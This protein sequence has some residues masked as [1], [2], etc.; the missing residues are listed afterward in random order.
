MD[1]QHLYDLLSDPKTP[2]L[3][4]LTLVL[5]FCYY[6]WNLGRLPS[7]PGPTP[8]PIL[9]NLLS[10]SPS[11]HTYFTTLSHTYGPIYKL[12][13]GTKTAIII[14]SPALAKE[15]LKDHDSVFSNRDVPAVAKEAAY[16]GKDIV[17]SQYGDEWRMLRK[18][19]VRELLGSSSIEAVYRL[20]R[21]ELRGMVKNLYGRIGEEINVGEV[22]FMTVMNVVTS[23]LWGG[24][25]DSSS[26]IGV[27][28]RKVVSEITDLLGKPNVSDFFPILGRFDLQGSQKKIR[29]L[30]ARF[31]H[32]FDVIIEGRL[33]LEEG[34][35]K[36]CKDFLQLM[37]RMQE[38]GGGKIPF[39]VL[40]LKALLMDMVV[41]GTDTTSNSVEWAVAEL[42]N[43]P[44]T[45]KKAQE[46]LDRVV[47]RDNILEESHLPQLNY[48][49]LVMKEVLRL[50]PALPL[51]VPHCP[52]SS[53]PIGGYIVE[54]GTRVFINVWA[55][56]RDPT[57]WN[58]P[59]EFDPERFL[60]GK[61]DYSGSNFSYFP[62]GSGRR[63]CAGIA[64][65]DRMFMY[66]LA[67]LLH[68]FDWSLKEGEK[69]D[70]KEKFGIVL[71]KA[72]PLVAVPTPRLSDP[73]LYV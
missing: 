72:T 58:N 50:H 15:I 24:S 9:G 42:M 59:S 62:F 2:A 41:G 39:T 63:I 65:A 70:L 11:L 19:C 35:R 38:E 43:K 17:W 68:S 69:M 3:I 31:D 61:W 12:K 4:F 33:K 1:I 30:F 14:S 16:N 60:T 66:E 36:E 5:L 26:N 23:M 7:P 51:L 25:D 32:I 37:L 44:E 48:L 8:L 22:L 56:H 27:E 64:M 6:T 18:V 55:I 45:M 54:K 28:F 21:R 57:I 49:Q 13:L 29:E 71:K 10:L 40:H 47:G 67:T 53:C 73:S 34:E 52:T 46:E 20:R